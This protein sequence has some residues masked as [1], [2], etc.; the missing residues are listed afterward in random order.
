MKRIIDVCMTIVLLFLMAYQVTGETLHEW[1]G[2]G[3]TVLVIVHQ[4]LNRKWYAALFKGKYRPYRTVTTTVN[5]LLLL[6]FALTAFCGMS[7]SGHAVPFLYGMAPVSFARRMHL[8][9][10]HWSFVLM[11]LH[12]GLHVP[13]MTAKMQL[14]GRKKTLASALFCC[15]AG[16]GLWFFLRNGMTDYLFFRVP[17]AFLDY[18]KAGALVILEN[19]IMLLF[20]AFTGTQ[21]SLLCLRSGSKEDEKKTSFPVIMIMAAVIIGL[22]LNANGIK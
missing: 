2:I 17:F 14:E 18:E 10:S 19:L 20:W 1:I 7:M 16:I 22:V 11:G 5:V 12:L 6:S 13:A 4:I 3:M 15:I 9:M 8:S 21:L